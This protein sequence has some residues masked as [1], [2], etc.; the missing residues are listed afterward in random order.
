MIFVI[1]LILALWLLTRSTERLESEGVEGKELFSDLDETRTSKEIK[2]SVQ[3]S[4]SIG[5]TGKPDRIEKTEDGR[6]RVLEYKSGSAPKEPY[7]NHK[8]QLACY[9][10]LLEE[11]R[12][13]KVKEGVISY[14]DG[15]RVVRITRSLKRKAKKKIEMVKKVKSEGFKPKRNH[16]NPAKCKKCEYKWVCPDPAI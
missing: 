1:I 8:I 16:S 11:R 10:L 9:A 6:T 3:K 5:L 7:S 4:P 13:Y 2:S 14:S 12:G 15:K